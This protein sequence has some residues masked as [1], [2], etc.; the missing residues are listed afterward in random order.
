MLYLQRQHVQ[1]MVDEALAGKPAEVCGVLAGR[2][3]RVWQVYPILNGAKKPQQQFYMDERGLWQALQMMDAAQQEMVGIYHSHPTSDAI[4]SHSD[5][6]AARRSYPNIPQIIISCKHAQ[7][8]LQGWKIGTA[9]ITP[10]ELI[11]GEPIQAETFSRAQ[12]GAILLAALL[13]LILMLTIAIQLL[14][15]APVLTPIAN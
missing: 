9:E 3:D 8:R 1:Q 14:P 6:D 13:A 2:K 4:P 10:V 7:P 12:V 11:I 15:P 5:V